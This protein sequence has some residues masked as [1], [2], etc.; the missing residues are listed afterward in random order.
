MAY[1]KNGGIL[2]I[3]GLDTSK[4]AEYIADQ[5]TPNCQNM[6]V[7][8]DVLK[9]R[10]G[11]TTVGATMSEAVM[12]GSEF[13]REEVKYVVRVGL[14]TLQEWNDVTTTW[15]DIT[16]TALNGSEDDAVSMA[17]PLLSAQRILCVTNFVD[18]IQK[19]TGTGT[20]AVLGGSP[21]KA[22][23]IMEYD[24]YLLLGYVD[25]GTARPMRIQWCDTADPETWSGGNSGSRDL[26]EDGENITGMGRFG[27]YAAIHKTTAI[28]LGYKVSSSTIFK[29][30]RKN[31][32]GT[33]CHN[34][35]QSLPT[36]DMAYLANDGIRLF[37]GIS[38]PLIEAPVTDD[39]RQGVNPEY[40]HRCWSVIVEEL[41]EYWLAVPIG[42]EEY[43]NT[44][45]KYNYRSKTC[46]KDTRSNITSAW[47]Y[48]QVSQPTWDDMTGTWEEATV[49]WDDKSLSS[50]FKL[51]IIGDSS[52]LTYKGDNTVIDDNSVLVDAYWESKDFQSEELGRLC[53][54]VG[55]DLW[56]KGNAVDVEYSIDKGQTWS[57]ISNGTVTLDANY[58]TDDAPDELWFDAVSSKIRFRFRNNESASTFYMKQFVIKYRNR[59]MRG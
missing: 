26:S 43:G 36:G 54:W 53:Q 31:V 52:G 3:Q 56:A 40:V 34:S 10:Y 6:S 38:A 57:A 51:I 18:A 5:N 12:G 37:N 42:S 17:T 11:T 14:T 8:R 33:I 28:Y 21:P 15:D 32:S 27:N 1:I 59:E 39:L 19:Y 20:C 45:Y 13:I 46:H 58:P 47:K 49:R 48:S 55:M 16:G 44:I 29:F 24:E 50:L 41:D 35:I 9:K 30:D 22:K 7:D 23:F 2:T 25:D 4:P